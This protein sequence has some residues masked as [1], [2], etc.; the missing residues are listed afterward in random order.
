M[1]TQSTFCEMWR[2]ITYFTEVSEK[3]VAPSPVKYWTETGSEQNRREDVRQR[4]IGGNTS[5]T[6]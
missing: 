3:T 1:E 6:G 5:L 2:W 4:V